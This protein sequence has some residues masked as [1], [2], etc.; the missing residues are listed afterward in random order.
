VTPT[1]VA[2]AS[3]VTGRVTHVEGGVVRKI[4]GTLRLSG[5][6]IDVPE[7]PFVIDAMP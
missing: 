5:P 3:Q 4:E 1:A 7:V 2:N 6:G